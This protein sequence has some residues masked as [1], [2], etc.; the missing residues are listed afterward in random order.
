MDLWLECLI[1]K[2][3]YFIHAVKLTSSHKTN[4]KQL[5]MLCKDFILEGEQCLPSSENLKFIS[6]GIASYASLCHVNENYLCKCFLE[7]TSL[8]YKAGNILLLPF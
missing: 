7:N 2:V 6:L 5:Y 1:K 8:F 4:M 3:S